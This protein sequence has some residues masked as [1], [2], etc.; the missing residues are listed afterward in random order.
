MPVYTYEML[1]L[2]NGPPLDTVE[3]SGNFVSENA[4]A[5]IGVTF[6]STS[7]PLHFRQVLVDFTDL[8]SDGAVAEDQG[9]DEPITYDLGSGPVTALLNSTVAYSMT[10]TY[11]PASG[12]PP[13]TATAGILQDSLGNMF[14]LGPA[15]ASASTIALGAAPILSIRINAIAQ[16]NYSGVQVPR[17]AVDFLCFGPGTRIRTRHGAVPV[18]RLRTGDLVATRDHGFQPLRLLASRRVPATGSLAPVVF[19]PGAIGNRRELVLSPQHRLLVRGAAAEL[20]FG[21]A[22]VLVPAVALVN[23]GDIVRREGG[24][25]EYHHLVFDRHEIVHAEGVEAESLLV[26]GGGLERMPAALQREVL[27]VF[28][29]AADWDEVAQ[30]VARPCVSRREGA[31]LAGSLAMGRRAV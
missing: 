17:F 29:E 11:G 15:T 3:G 20:F 24:T 28:P 21:E 16:N 8:N 30:P 14:L 19:A 25:I 2:G 6:G 4:A 26:G 31:L 18:E 22:E 7:A 13:V 12:R 23:G 1:F 5:L 27:A 10:I 9:Q